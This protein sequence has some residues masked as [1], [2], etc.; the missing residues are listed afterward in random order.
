MRQ[1]FSYNTFKQISYE[2]S[3][4]FASHCI[5]WLITEIVYP[6]FQ[7]FSPEITNSKDY[8]K[9]E[10]AIAVTA[11]KGGEKLITYSRGIDRT[12]TVMMFRSCFDC[13]RSSL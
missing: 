1:K 8:Q 11:N 2:Y 3:N 5:S 12:C 7:L 4:S 13:S 9:D 10:A 6:K